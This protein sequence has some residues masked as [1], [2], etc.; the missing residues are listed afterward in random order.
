M[1]LG[2]ASPGTSMARRGRGVVRRGGASAAHVGH[3]MV[4]R[5]T[6][7]ATTRGTVLRGVTLHIF[8]RRR[9]ARRRFG[10]IIVV[11]SGSGIVGTAAATPT[12]GGRAHGCVGG[13][14]V[15]LLIPHG[16]SREMGKKC[17]K[18]R[19]IFADGRNNGYLEYHAGYNANE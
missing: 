14:A 1:S 8:G 18:T 19:Q 7:N 9:T 13:G 10:I 4:R 5:R 17:H 2:H 12:S 11:R 16:V 3:G 6:S 15:Y